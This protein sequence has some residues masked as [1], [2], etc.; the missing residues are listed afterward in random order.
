MN[1]KKSKVAIKFTHLYT[2]VDRNEFMLFYA[3]WSEVYMNF[4]FKE[5]RCQKKK[6]IS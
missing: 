5:K 3:Y 2:N 4:L 1:P 6:N